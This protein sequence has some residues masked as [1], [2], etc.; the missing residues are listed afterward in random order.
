MDLRDFAPADCQNSKP[1]LG[2][3]EIFHLFRRDGC[4]RRLAAG[5][6]FSI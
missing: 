4:D 6:I 1:N 2:D 3:G 5:V